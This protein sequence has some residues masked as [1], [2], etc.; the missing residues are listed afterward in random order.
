MES[1]I[2]EVL[3]F[4][5][6]Y[7]DGN[8]DVQ[9]LEN[10]V[11]AVSSID[12]SDEARKI[13]GEEA[14]IISVDVM[15]SATSAD[16]SVTETLR[17]LRI[18]EAGTKAEREKAIELLEEIELKSKSSDAAK[19]LEIKMLVSRLRE[20]QER[21]NI[22]MIAMRQ[23]IE[24]RSKSLQ[25][26]VRTLEGLQ[27]KYKGDLK[28]LKEQLDV[29]DAKITKI[30]EDYVEKLREK[31]LSL[32]ESYRKEFIKRY[33][34]FKIE[35]SGLSLHESSRA[36][37]EKKHTVEEV[38][39]VF[40]EVRDAMRRGALHAGQVLNE[41]TVE[42]TAKKDPLREKISSVIEGIGF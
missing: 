18:S 22:E 17:A 36:L 10:S 38:D 5:V 33:T 24:S 19:S 30:A 14:E 42:N 32:E 1:K 31:A 34:D 20:I 26:V 21:E 8:G 9:T 16:L 11:R 28:K 12:A 25:I 2:E 7:K 35:N 15:S 39:A 40:E 3:D 4:S 37:L 41:V 13:I 23:M 29:Q 27:K 6:R